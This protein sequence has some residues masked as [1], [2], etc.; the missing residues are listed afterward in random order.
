MPSY[1][2]EVPSEYGYVLTA[3]VSSLLVH[4]YHFFL[5]V[6]A[7]KASGIAYPISYATQEQADKDPNAYLFNCA[8]RAHANYTEAL[9]PFV[10]SLLISGLRYPIASAVLGG[11]WAVARIVYAT[12]YARA[13]PKGRQ[14]GNGF[15]LLSDLS[16]K[17]MAV[18]AC[19]KML[20]SA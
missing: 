20:P 17:I 5:T 9:T 7:R 18:T 10:G 11:T 19:I 14:L 3:A 6:R 15:G 16:L 12:G 8:Q 2:L 4:T 13:G 1:A